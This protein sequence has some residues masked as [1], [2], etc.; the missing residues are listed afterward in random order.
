ML[1]DRVETALSA[2]S[3]PG[4]DVE[5]RGQRVVLRGIV[6]NDADI[7]AARR[8]ALTAAGGGGPWAGGVTSVNTQAVL[9]GSFERPFAWSVEARSLARRVEQPCRVRTPEPI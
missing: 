3:F 4:I 7:V 2:E 9:V 6:E 8:A 1:R 5:M